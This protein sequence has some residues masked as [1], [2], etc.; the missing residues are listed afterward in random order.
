MKAILLFIQ[1]ILFL[2]IFYTVYLINPIPKE[3]NRIRRMIRVIFN[4][5]ISWFLL[6][7]ILGQMIEPTR[8]EGILAKDIDVFLDSD[9]VNPIFHLPKGLTTKDETP[10]GFS[11]IGVLGD[12]FMLSITIETNSEDL[13][14]FSHTEKESFH[15]RGSARVKSSSH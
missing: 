3:D 12:S 14:D 10:V 7:S 8:S 4:I 9:P 1:F 13:I 6:M 5:L 15:L 2:P 11:A